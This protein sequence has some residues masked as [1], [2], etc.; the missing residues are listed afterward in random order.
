M[1]D[2][3]NLDLQ[4]VTS[5]VCVSLMV[6][7]IVLQMRIKSHWEP[8]SYNLT[9]FK[10]LMGV[11]VVHATHSIAHLARSY[12]WPSCE[13]CH[14]WRLYGAVLYVLSRIVTYAFFLMR[15]KMSQNLAPVVSMKCFTLYYPLSLLVMWISFT[16]GAVMYTLNNLIVKCV[17]LGSIGDHFCEYEVNAADNLLGTSA[18]ILSELVN[19]TILLYLFVRPFLI[20]YRNQN[21][22]HESPELAR[23]IGNRL[24]WNVGMTAINLVSTN[25]LLILIGLVS[26]NNLEVCWPLDRALN[27]VSSFLILKQN[28]EWLARNARKVRRALSSTFR[29][30]RT[31]VPSLS[32]Y[33]FPEIP[34]RAHVLLNPVSECSVVVV[35][36]RASWLDTSGL[37]IKLHEDSIP[38]RQDTATDSTSEEKNTSDSADDEDQKQEE[39]K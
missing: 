23:V 35:D 4:R 38:I 22:H 14:F 12:A 25:I 2:E 32:V 39:D 27:V 7:T 6:A 13:W 9:F 15:A 37:A 26:T 30:E 29:S 16:Y 33:T 21:A 36:S 24:T 11:Y 34:Q 31:G 10:L 18:G 3:I 20:F 19:T 17:S 5:W 28:R 8:N 1:T